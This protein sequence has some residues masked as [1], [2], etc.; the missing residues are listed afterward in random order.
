MRDL[1]DIEKEG[2]R[3]RCAGLSREEAIIEGGRYLAENMVLHWTTS[4]V[5]GVIFKSCEKKIKS[6]GRVR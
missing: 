5:E 6:R 1:T 2:M 3:K 4:D